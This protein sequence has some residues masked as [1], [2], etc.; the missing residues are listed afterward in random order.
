[1]SPAYNE[2]LP[3]WVLS[4]CIYVVRRNER[5]YAIRNK[6]RRAQC[7]YEIFRPEIVDLMIRARAILSEVGTPTDGGGRVYTDKDIPALGKN[8]MTNEARC[9]GIDAY[10]FYIRLYALKGLLFAV[11][12]CLQQGRDASRVL[13]P[14]YIADPRYEHE[15]LLLANEF[16]ERNA[17]D[18]LKEL[19]AAQQ[20][21]AGDTLLSKEKDD[22]RGVRIVP[23]YVTTHVPAREDPFVKV[24]QHEAAELTAEVAE[25]LKK[26]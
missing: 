13:E 12:L 20:K 19:V 18:L 8:Y 25:I 23:D 9:N 17:K 5:K 22:F 4:D 26:L 7:A 16:P 15:R 3:G 6:A 21:V 10:T 2:I 1:M 24:T 14:G 11:K